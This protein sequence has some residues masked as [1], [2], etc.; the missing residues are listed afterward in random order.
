M[1]SPHDLPEGFEVDQP[2]Q[3]LPPGFELDQPKAFSV[4]PGTWG[5]VMRGPSKQA[6]AQTETFTEPRRWNPTSD[7]T[8]K[9]YEN[10]Q[11]GLP[12]AV[13]AATGLPAVGAGVGRLATSDLARAAVP[14][15]LKRGAQMFGLPA[16][17]G[18][19]LG[20]LGLV[21]LF[22][23]GEKVEKAAKTVGDAA[24]QAVK[25]GL[26]PEPPPPRHGRTS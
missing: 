17:V 16:E 9:A 8:A 3:G 22:G 2:S 15:A 6:R 21:K 20:D 25:E 5:E 10:W 1:P 24:K 12:G 26:A 14:F 4:R 7:V 13:M 23:A 19:Y 11:S 18:E